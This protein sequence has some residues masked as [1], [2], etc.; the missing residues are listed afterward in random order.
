MNNRFNSRI[1]IISTIQNI[2]YIVGSIEVISIFSEITVVIGHSS[3]SMC[4]TD[5]RSLQM[6][7]TVCEY[8]VRT[9]VC[10]GMGVYVYIQRAIA[11]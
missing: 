5:S 11:C 2:S 1:Y 7:V 6:H 4:L 10:V 8:L 9:H 3:S